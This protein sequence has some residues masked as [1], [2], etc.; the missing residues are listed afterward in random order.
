MKR[1][2]IIGYGNPLR[3][4]DG[5]G[6][7]AAELV[8]RRLAPGTAGVVQC[9]Q[10]TPELALEVGNASMVIFLDAA[11]GAE[12]GCISMEAISGAEFSSW[13][14]HFTPRQLLA[15]VNNP[16][17]AYWI[18]ASASA[19]GWRESL[20]PEGEHSAIKMAEAALKLLRE[21][22]WPERKQHGA[23]PTTHTICPTRHP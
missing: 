12:P 1:P 3:E 6:S 22:A 13:T 11:V 21:Q 15:L 14:H 20:T 23:A 10:L 8:E 16:P 7:R 5:I 18:T 9:R 17:P 4:D 2:L 19:L